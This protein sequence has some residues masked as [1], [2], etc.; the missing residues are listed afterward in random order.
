M[1]EMNNGVVCDKHV[2]T[3]KLKNMGVESVI[4]VEKL[5]EFKMNI[6]RQTIWAGNLQCLVFTI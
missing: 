5:L 6:V 2:N 4:N 1:Y 3:L